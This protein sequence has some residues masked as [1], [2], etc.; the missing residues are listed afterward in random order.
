MIVRRSTCNAHAIS[1][2]IGSGMGAVDAYV[3]L[4]VVGIDQAVVLS[5]R[6][7]D[8][9]HVAVSRIPTLGYAS[10]ISMSI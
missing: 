10:D 3:G 9:I 5:C 4:I 2:A 7:I 8:V 1:P 6:L